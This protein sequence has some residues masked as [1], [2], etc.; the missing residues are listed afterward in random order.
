MVELATL[1]AFP[2]FPFFLDCSETL[3]NIYLKTVKMVTFDD[4]T[5]GGFNFFGQHYRSYGRVMSNA[6]V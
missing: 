4:F 5:Y 2:R 6:V 3:G 1:N